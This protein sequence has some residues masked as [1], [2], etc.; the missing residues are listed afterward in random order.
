MRRTNFKKLGL[1]ILNQNT[2]EESRTNNPEKNN[3]L[4]TIKLSHEQQI[5]VEPHNKTVR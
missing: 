1:G 5:L 4:T 2:A 3:T